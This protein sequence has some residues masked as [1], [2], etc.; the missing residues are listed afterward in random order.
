MGKGKICPIK[1][2]LIPRSFL[3]DAKSCLFSALS[4]FHFRDK[5]HLDSHGVQHLEN[6]FKTRMSFF[7]LKSRFFN[8]FC[9]KFHTFL[10]FCVIPGLKHPIF[11]A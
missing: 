3:S 8:I 10:N 11:K 4:K 9:G 1:L 5:C 2:H 6:G 7:L